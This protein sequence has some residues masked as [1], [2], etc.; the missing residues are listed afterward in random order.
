VIPAVSLAVLLASSPGVVVQGVPLVV[1]S[2]LDGER[3]ELITILAAELRGRSLDRRFVDRPKPDAVAVECDGSAVRIAVASPAAA[4]GATAT[5]ELGAFQ[6]R[7]RPRLIALTIAELIMPASVDA[8]GETAPLASNRPA[9]G[10][11]A[12]ATV[13]AGPRPGARPTAWSGLEAL[14]GGRTPASAGPLLWGGGVR[15]GLRRGGLALLLDLVY[16][17][18]TRQFPIGTVR[19]QVPSAGLFLSS[20]PAGRLGVRLAA[21]LRGGMVLARGSAQDAGAAQ[22]SHRGPW[23]GPAVAATL[24]AR[25]LRPV[26]LA[27]GVEGGWAL[28]RS[29]G[30]V[31]GS[32]RVGMGGSWIGLQVAIG[33]TP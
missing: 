27:L 29:F 24:V 11:Q 26:Q 31:A 5:V 7:T 30:V 14:A 28:A 3:D 19:L 20:M 8:L 10:P 15:G 16:E 6:R 23:A 1:D 25:P 17:Q 12:P 21:G 18:G 22:G 4:V 32:E 2:C 9:P 33:V 13:V